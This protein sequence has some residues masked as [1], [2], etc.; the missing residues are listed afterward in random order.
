M[1]NQ[2]IA[3]TT[4]ATL[5]RIVGVVKDN[6][7]YLAG[8]TGLSL[9]LGHRESIDLDF[10]TRKS[11]NPKMIAR[12]LQ[13][14]S[15]DQEGEGT[16]HGVVN[17]TKITFLY[18]EYPLIEKFSNYIDIPVASTID[19]ATMKLNAILRRNTKKDFIDLYF[20]LK[21]IPLEILIDAF[22]KKYNLPNLDY[23]ILKSLT[24]FWDADTEPMP[25]MLIDVQWEKVKKELSEIATKYLDNSK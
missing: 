11:F 5:E 14:F 16:L 17:S 19:I 21:N 18:Y 8:G 13:D 1:F 6:D 15:L 12:Q 7:F 23:S 9:Q 4:K 2:G 20:I 25:V 10:F 3:E 24:Y 22:N